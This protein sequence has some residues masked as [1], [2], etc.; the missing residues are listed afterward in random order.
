MKA[1]SVLFNTIA[2]ILLL[3][4][5]AP[6]QSF[7]LKMT[8]EPLAGIYTEKFFNF[9]ETG[10][11]I[12][13]RLVNLGIDSENIDLRTFTDR[14]ILTVDKIDTARIDLIEKV[15][16]VPG[17]IEFWETYENSEIVQSLIEANNRLRE[18]KVNTD[19]VVEEK[20]KEA[21]SADSSMKE[22]SEITDLINADTTGNASAK[23]YKVNNPLFA[24]LYPRVDG[25]GQPLQS[26]M[27]GL[28]ALKDTAK[29]NR[30]LG[31]KE[32]YY[33]FPRDLRFYW[34]HSPYKYDDTQ[35]LFELHAI[36]A[37]SIL[38][39]APLSGDVIVSAK[40]I[41]SKNR[42]DIRLNLSMNHEGAMT[43]ARI[44]RD[45]INRCIAVVIDGYVRSYPRVMNEIKGGNTEITGNFSLGEAQYLSAILSSGGNGL[46]LKLQVAE[47]LVTK[48]K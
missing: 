6:K 7:D 47:K 1:K 48:S 43:W 22:N 25:T 26:C 19:E 4:G 30:Y 20:A 34:S 9:G 32:L 45:N 44:T 16:T 40:A 33:I 42:S 17:R 29:I 28:V 38:G 12:K 14:M 36:K 27:I 11:I 5:C 3:S 2:T 37:T 13:K 39:D 8:I 21:I 15:I 35:T 24:I 46:P 23:E 31:M 10:N 41:M 18:M